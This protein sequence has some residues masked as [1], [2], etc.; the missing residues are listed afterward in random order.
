MI[1]IMEYHD[2]AITGP[3]LTSI[4]KATFT[5]SKATF[6]PMPYTAQPINVRPANGLKAGIDGF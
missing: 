6:T 1:E 3:R 5:I 2:P 4:S